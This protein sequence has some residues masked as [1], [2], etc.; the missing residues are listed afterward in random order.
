VNYALD[1]DGAIVIRTDAGTKLAA[2]NHATVTFEVEEIDQRTRSGW[3]VLVRGLA[4]EVTTEHRTELIE[5]TKAS[6]VEPWALDVPDTAGD[7]RPSDRAGGA[8]PGLRARC[9]PVIHEVLLWS[10]NCDDAE[11]LYQQLITQR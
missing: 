10:R 11:D 4:E 6:G 3:S 9:L 5:R 7:Q 1:H 2:A 8:A